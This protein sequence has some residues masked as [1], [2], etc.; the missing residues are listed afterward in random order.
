MN[1]NLGVQVDV[2]NELNEF[3]T[4]E[5]N[6]KKRSLIKRVMSILLMTLIF[7]F[8]LVKKRNLNEN[9]MYQMYA[10]IVEHSCWL[11]QTCD[12]LLK[13]KT[14]VRAMNYMIPVSTSLM[15]KIVKGEPISAS[16]II[17]P[18]T[19]SYAL[20]TAGRSVGHSVQTALNLTKTTLNIAKAY[21]GLYTTLNSLMPLVGKQTFAGQMLPLVHNNLT[22]CMSLL[23]TLASKEF[24]DG[25]KNLNNII[26]LRQIRDN[27]L[28]LNENARRLL[29]L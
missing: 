5:I 11:F 24:Y 25:K 2:H 26:R 3:I 1:L 8:V 15:H 6:L 28:R 14:F 9:T 4:R 20:N 29:Q 18:L 10:L 13:R 19:A 23:G 22:Q 17:H 21:P 27:R 7:C 16:S 12:A